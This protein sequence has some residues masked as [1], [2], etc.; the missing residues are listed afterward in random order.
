METNTLNNIGYYGFAKIS[1]FRGNKLIK[2]TIA[3]NN[4]TVL[5]FKLLSSALCGVY[6]AN[7]MPRYID[8]G[9]FENS[10]F[11]SVLTSR[12]LL[13]SKVDENFSIWD[14]DIGTQIARYGAS[15]TSIIPAVQFNINEPK[16]I[17]NLRLYSGNTDNN[18]LAEISLNSNN[19]IEVNPS[20]GYNYI[21]EWVMIFDNVLS[22]N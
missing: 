9:I 13:S 1:T 4:G 7:S 8:I 2:T 6:N 22:N 16:N 12:P 20:D 11:T 21:I 17:N 14:A 19:S 5:L 10:T 3:H 18:L 15:F